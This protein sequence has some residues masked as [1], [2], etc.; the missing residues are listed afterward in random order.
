MTDTPFAPLPTELNAAGEPRRTGV[1]IEFAGLREGD[2]ARIL[3]RELGGTARQT[4]DRDWLV[5]GSALG[6]IEVYLDTV[7]RKWGDSALLD[8][9]LRMGQEVIPVEIVT[10]PLTRE[11]LARLDAARDALRR[12][13]A[14]GSR[15][16]ILYG[17]GVHLNVE[18]ASPD[19]AGITRPLMAYAL[20]EDWMREAAQ[21]D[22]SRRLLPF[23]DPYPTSLV[24]ALIAAGPD[25]AP[26]RAMEVY[27][28]HTT[29]RNH[30]LDMLP[31]FA[32]LDRAT[33][34]RATSQAK[35]LKAR[36]AFHFRLP[37][38]RID[39]PEWSLAT[40]WERW[41]LVER[42]AADPALLDRL[43]QA[44]RD[45]H[46]AVTLSRYAWAERASEILLAAGVIAE[47]GLV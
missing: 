22:V 39:E 32:H 43:G 5:E 30:G 1:E 25:A 13:G 14:E 36:P 38:S 9:G 17:F 33:V 29:S 45:E 46:W 18:I 35:A 12:A 26:H 34:E 7:I 23:T 44:W 4:D 11:G 41:V 40:E 42:V 6:D 20:I 28:A 19:A 27:L 16:G 21:I 47:R 15:Q 2:A 10:K 24:R 3:A 31:L 8:A 37:D